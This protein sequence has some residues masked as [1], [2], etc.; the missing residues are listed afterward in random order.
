MEPDG[1]TWENAAF[2]TVVTAAHILLAIVIHEK[3][4][5][6][7]FEVSRERGAS[8]TTHAAFADQGSESG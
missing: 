6:A 1:R 7:D 8:I 3:Y 4:S 2:V 5:A